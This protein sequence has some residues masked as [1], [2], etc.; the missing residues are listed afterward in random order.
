MFYNHCNQSKQVWIKVTVSTNWLRLFRVVICTSPFILAQWT[1]GSYSGALAIL[2]AGDN[3]TTVKEKWTCFADVIHGRPIWR[4]SFVPDAPFQAPLNVVWDHRG[5][6][7]WLFPDECCC[8]QGM[9]EQSVFCRRNDSS[10][11]RPC[12]NM[13]ILA[14][15]TDCESQFLVYISTVQRSRRRMW[16]ESMLRLDGFRACEM[17]TR[18][19]MISENAHHAFHDVFLPIR[20]TANTMVQPEEE[21][22]CLAMFRN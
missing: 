18:V 3:A 14:S 8:K 10:D 11:F 12:V 9:L 4:P 20:N 2:F 7:Q 21:G 1:A 13:T 19:S 22:D 15:F 16:C 17:A 5:L 6:G